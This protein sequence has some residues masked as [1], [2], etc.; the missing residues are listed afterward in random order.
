[1]PDS[2]DKDPVPPAP[3]Q[4]AAET[5]DGPLQA[6]KRARAKHGGFSD[7]DGESVVVDAIDGIG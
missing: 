3:L 5:S 4:P 1:M 2:P 7:T 6:T